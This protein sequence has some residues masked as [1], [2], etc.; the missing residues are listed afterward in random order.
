MGTIS[1]A[2][3]VNDPVIL[4]PHQPIT[5]RM[6][7]RISA[8]VLL[9]L[10]TVVAIRAQAADDSQTGDKNA[11]VFEGVIKSDVYGVGKSIRINGTVTEGAIAFGGDVI[12]QGIVNGDVAAIGGSVIQ[13]E[14]SQIGGDVIVVGGTY[15]HA[16]KIPKRNP[17]S[18]TVMYAGYEQELRNMMR[19]PTGLLAPGWTPTYLGLRL[20]SILFWFVISLALTAAL[21]GA[22]SRGVAR[23]Q[24]TSLRVAA[25]GFLG[26]IVV[27]T[28]VEACLFIL[29]TPFSTLLGM[30][31]I[32][33]IVLAGVFGR[34]VIYAATGRWI[35]RKFLPV[36]RNSESMALLLGTVFWSLLSSLPYVWPF[37]IALTLV[38]SLGLALTAGRSNI[39][40]KAQA[41]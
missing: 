12:V 6:L 33:F 7:Y 24:L 14:G 40:K 16:D 28:G 34:V 23:L 35:Q 11:Q 17:A 25:I 31:T 2:A 41:V 10:L 21:P 38:L 1:Q 9:L 4:R 18:I 30:M 36:G 32:L 39:W 27:G 19:N 37:I 13:L 26:A 22:V 29:P 8:L 20:L 3:T 5:S 15:R